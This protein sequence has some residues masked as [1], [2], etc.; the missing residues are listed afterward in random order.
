MRRN[1]LLA[2]VVVSAV[3]AMVAMAPAPAWACTP[4]ES[5]TTL[6]AEVDCQLH[7]TKTFQWTIDKAVTPATL[8]MFRGDS[9]SAEYTITVT[10]DG[11]VEEAWVDGQITV[12]NGGAVATENLAITAVLK[13][14]YG[15]PN[16]FLASAPVDVSGNPVLD[17]GETGVYSYRVNIPVTGGS[18]PQP[19]AGGTYKVTANV[20]ITNHSGHLGE[21]FGPSPSCT[22]TMPGCPVLV[23]DSIHVND[24][25][26]GSWAFSDDGST[27][28]EKE[29][30][31]DGDEGSHNN[32]ATIQETG[33]YDT[34]AVTVNCYALTVTKDA[35]T[36]LTRTYGWIIDKSAN[37]GDGDSAGNNVPALT[38]ATGQQ[39][40]VDYTVTVNLDTPAYDDTDWAVSGTITIANPAPMDA[41]LTAV[42]D[43]VSAAIAATVT[44]PTLT[45]PAGGT[46]S[47]TYEASLP[48][49]ESRVN[50]ATA[51]LQNTPAGTT[52]F[53]GTAAVDFASATINKV[54]ECITV[55]DDK[56]DP[57]NPVELGE[58][59]E[60]DTL[61]YSFTYQ[62]PF[63]PFGDTECGN[64][65]VENIASFV[66]GDTE[67]EGSDNWKVAVTITGCP[68]TTGCTLTPG[69]WK[70]HSEYGPAPYDDNWMNL[71]PMGEDSVFFLS[72]QTYYQVMWTSPKG[73]NA[74]YILAHAYIG[75]EL[76]KLNGASM[77]E[78]V[79]DAFE[80]TAALFGTYTPNGV[81]TLKGKNASAVRAS[82]LGYAAI[83]DQYNNGLALEGPPHCSETPVT[84]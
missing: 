71:L 36:S 1:V 54:D 34:A 30:T 48:G 60:G 7:W 17:P 68:S 64:F 8:D 16:D 22:D 65:F 72:G 44:C 47:C 11:G 41:T 45:V 84:P 46:L 31:C 12:Y 29:F 2:V 43:V 23:N 73:G 74:Y 4:G 67:T 75:A 80:G 83:L 3:A 10:K 21:A 79:E 20:T 37:Y 32:T 26:G 77:P 82:F 14:G 53:S 56:G 35:A 66:T 9:G 15:A 25:N 69:Y 58:V 28:Y 49:A 63:G 78:A 50:T 38:L 5:G 33:Q 6:S 81:V 59:C 61:P 18:F 70:T 76:N 13:N 51:T 55:S 57:A 40:S 62:V 39:I 52:D 19:H 24:S 27:S 42:G